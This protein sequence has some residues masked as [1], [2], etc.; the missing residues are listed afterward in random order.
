MNIHRR[1]R[2]KLRESMEESALSL[3]V[4]PSKNTAAAGSHEDE[5]SGNK[6]PPKGPRTMSAEDKTEFGPDRIGPRTSA[7]P[8]AP[9]REIPSESQIILLILRYTSTAQRLLGSSTRRLL[10][11]YYFC[12]FTY[13]MSI[14]LRM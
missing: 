8:R 13:S 14:L 9:S 6:T 3:G 10:Y 12:Y 5:K 4:I 11:L 2:A 1:D 7:R